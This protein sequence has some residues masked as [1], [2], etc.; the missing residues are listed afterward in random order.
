[1]AGGVKTLKAKIC[2]QKDNEQNRMN[3]D[4]KIVKAI[5]GE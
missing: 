5:G 4:V 3:I 1:M 2:K